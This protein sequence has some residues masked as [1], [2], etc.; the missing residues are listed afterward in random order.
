MES[1]IR[2]AKVKLYAFSRMDENEDEEFLGLSKCIQVQ[3]L[4]PSLSF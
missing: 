2:N 1:L 4:L 3:V